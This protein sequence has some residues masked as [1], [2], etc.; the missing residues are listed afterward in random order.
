MNIVIDSGTFLL[1]IALSWIILIIVT[2][3]KWVA[4][5]NPEVGLGYVIFRT[6]KFNK[7]ISKVTFL[8]TRFWRWLFDIG[9]LVCLG[10]IFAA[11]LMFSIN[12]V[13][14]LQIALHV[15]APID[16]ICSLAY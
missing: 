9:L 11:L 12:I 7:I 14:F 4:L 8:S 6:E 16:T 1:L 3:N 13:K 2:N 10:F 5:K 15:V